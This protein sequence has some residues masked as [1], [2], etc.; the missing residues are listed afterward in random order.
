MWV[1]YYKEKEGYF[2]PSFNMSP[3]G[4]TTELV[5][6]IEDAAKPTQ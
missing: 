6:V 5:A 2:Y 3:Q 4:L 1:F